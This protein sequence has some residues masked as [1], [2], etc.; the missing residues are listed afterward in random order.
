MLRG[1]YGRVLG[2]ASMGLLPQYCQFQILVP[3][4]YHVEKACRMLRGYCGLE[5]GID[6]RGQQLLCC[7]LLE[8]RTF[9][10]H[11]DLRDQ[12]QGMYTMGQQPQHFL[13]LFAQN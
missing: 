6:S 8:Y 3:Y 12:V 7:Q 11:R 10:G 9:R 13:L 2:I 5:L 1:Y 4:S